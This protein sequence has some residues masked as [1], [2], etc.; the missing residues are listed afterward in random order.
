[1]KKLL[2]VIRQSE[3]TPLK[4]AKSD[5]EKPKTMFEKWADYEA[6]YSLWEC[7]SMT[8]ALLII[9]A[10]VLVKA[11]GWLILDSLYFTLVLLTTVGYGDIFPKTPEGKLFASLSAFEWR[12]HHWSGI[13]S[14][15]I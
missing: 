1:M 12:C 9:G 7:F 10:A 4:N 5:D 11:E 8:L 2:V 3:R 13:G 15:W 6:D 14:G